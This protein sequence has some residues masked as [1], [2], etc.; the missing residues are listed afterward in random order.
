M[1][2]NTTNGQHY[3]SAGIEAPRSDRRK[4][5]IDEKES[6]AYYKGRKTLR[7]TGN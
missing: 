1:L 4:T 5:K 6:L 2:E 3:V 7:K